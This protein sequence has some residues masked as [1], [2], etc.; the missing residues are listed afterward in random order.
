MQTKILQM[1]KEKVADLETKI[2]LKQNLLQNWH[3]INWMQLQINWKLNKA[4]LAEIQEEFDKLLRLK[5][6]TT[7]IYQVGIWSILR[8]TSG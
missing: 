5:E 4:K 6:R 2:E 3:K 8:E 7:T 1:R